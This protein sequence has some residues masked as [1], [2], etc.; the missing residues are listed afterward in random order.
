MSYA[1]IISLAPVEINASLPHTTPARISIPMGNIDQPSLCVLSDGI[2]RR[3]VGIAVSEKDPW[4]S[5]PVLAFDL[6]KSIADDYKKSA[7]YVEPDAYPGVFVVQDVFGEKPGPGDVKYYTGSDETLKFAKKF[8][9][10]YTDAKTKQYNWL[11]K[12]VQVADK[13]FAK[14]SNYAEISTLQRQAAKLLRLERPWSKEIKPEDFKNCPFCM[15]FLEPAAVVCL[16]CSNVVDVEKY[17]SLKSGLET[18][19]K[20]VV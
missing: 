9:K 4:V 1:T 13:S 17:N 15:S 6:A 12:Q 3:Y 2:E 20:K 18:S 16:H 11:K 8:E 10:E 14:S 5:Y 7:T 19:N